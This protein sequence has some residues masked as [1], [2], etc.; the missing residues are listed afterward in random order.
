MNLFPENT[1][2]SDSKT[3]QCDWASADRSDV[4][5]ARAS[6]HVV[7]EYAPPHG[8]IACATHMDTIRSKW[9]FFAAHPFEEPCISGEFFDSLNSC[10]KKDE[11]VAALGEGE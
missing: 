6:W 10:F 5:L 8:S 11:P 1:G 9:I 7:W 3:D 2:M 4:C